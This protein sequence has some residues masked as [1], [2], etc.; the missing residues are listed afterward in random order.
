M[1]KTL[2]LLAP[3]LIPSWRFF[4]TI[5]ASPRIEVLA[6]GAPDAPL[7]DPLDAA[8]RDWRECRP[9]PRH[10]PPAV[11]A[12]RLL[13]N[14]GWNDTLYMTSCAERLLE[15]ETPHSVAEIAARTAAPPDARTAP[16]VCTMIRAS[17]SPSVSA[18]SSVMR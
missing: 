18:P 15:H 10:L 13:W 5:T 1:L 9:R 17:T 16:F 6:L 4:D 7:H 3:A 2:R 11:L 12:R 8:P 14:P